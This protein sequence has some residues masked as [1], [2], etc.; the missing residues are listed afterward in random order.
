MTALRATVVISGATAADAAKP[1]QLA[2][3][4]V[5]ELQFDPLRFYVETVA[6]PGTIP[7]RVF[8]GARSDPGMGA[9]EQRV[10]D[11]EAAILSLQN[12]DTALS[13]DIADL[14]AG[15]SWFIAEPPDDVWVSSG[16]AAIGQFV[17]VDLFAAG[18]DVVVALPAPTAGIRGRMVHVAEI[19]SDG[20]VTLG[21]AVKVSGVFA[22][23]ASGI[24]SPHVIGATAA[25]PALSELGARAT[26]ICTGTAWQL[27]SE[28]YLVR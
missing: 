23:P 6:G 3:E 22:S 25:N 9:L 20:G 11:T 17:Q 1:V 16:A 18:S 27:F 13:N 26:F 28:T 8:V 2:G 12:T 19:S 24:A 10:A 7:P 14:S 15:G 5:R 21:L 4:P